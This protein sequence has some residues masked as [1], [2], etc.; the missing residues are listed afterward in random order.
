MKFGRVIKD[1]RRL[2]GITQ[3][4]LAGLIN[5]T[6]AYLSTVETDKK[7]PSIITLERI[8][9][10]L[11][12]PIFYFFFMGMEKKDIPANKLEVYNL[13]GPPLAEMIKSIFIEDD[14]EFIN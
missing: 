10:C 8:S 6:Q 4:E 12:V 7:T 14:K 2:Q 1:T 3:G 5:V 13:A 9:K 11:G